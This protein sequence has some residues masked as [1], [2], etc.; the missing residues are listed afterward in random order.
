M[1]T[2][3]SETQSGRARIGAAAAAAALATALATAPA[4]AAATD[5]APDALNI[6]PAGQY[7][8]PGPGADVQ[9]KMYDGLTPLFR[10]VT[11][12]DL[13][14]YF[15][16][17]RFGAGGQGPTTVEPIPGKPG[18][19]VVRDRFNVP[20]V[21]AR[22]RADI[23][24]ATGW[25]FAEDRHLLL[26]Q[27][28]F[29]AR[30]EAVDVPNLDGFG[31]VVGL[32]QFV[33]SAAT[34]RRIAQQT[35]VLQGAGAVGRQIL[36]DIDAYTAGINQSYRDHGY[37]L[38]QPFTRVDIY[39]VMALIGDIFGRGGGD[40][41][42]RS[43][44]LDGLQRRLGARAGTQAFND[45]RERQDPEAVVTSPGRFPY[46]AAPAGHP[47]NVVLDNGSFQE[48][49]PAKVSATA[50]ASSR[51]HASN[52]LVV[53]RSR[54]A[55]GRPLFV[56]GPQIGYNFPGL[57]YELDLH[58]GG[59]DARGASAPGLPGYILIGRNQDAAWSLTSAGNDLIDTFAETLCGGS[60]RRY[61][62]QGRCRTMTRFDA[63]VL[64]GAGSA[65]DQRVRFSETVHGPVV[66]YGRVRGRLV[67]LTRDRASRG[68]DAA[69]LLPFEAMSANRVRSPKDFI[70]AFAKSPFTFNAIYADHRDIATY[71]AGLLPQRAP[72]VDIGLPTKGTGQYEWRG[73]LPAR[74]H[75]QSIDPPSGLLVNWNGKP[76]LGFSS[77]D[78]EWTYGSIQRKDLL[79]GELARTSKHTLAT[80]T[81]A[82]NAAAT[83]DLY[84][85][86][87]WPTIRA[88]L[89]PGTGPGARAEQLA[90]LLDR[91]RAAGGSRLDRD[92][93]GKVDDPGA[94][95]MDVAFPRLG[96]AALQPVLGAKLVRQLGTLISPTDPA[97]GGYFSGWQGYLDKDLRR[98]AGR[99]V[100]GPYALR[101]CGR[102]SLARCRTDLWRALDQAGA[103]LAAKQ[104]P[105]PAAW[106]ASAA[107][108]AIEFSPL[109][110]ITVRWT[111]RP[112]GIQQVISFSGHR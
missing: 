87:A 14:T 108:E 63:G 44:F 76:A 86:R 77:A 49:V 105:D 89:K 80:V 104:G 65:P 8:L 24:F 91:W 55:T 34:D 92:G 28:R 96:A 23:A 5:Y 84:V 37:P 46:G 17:A 51:R 40:E 103:A 54:S 60:K 53:G 70:G 9:A 21:T 61:L 30:V 19:T 95:I 15:K 82:M 48:E 94:A 26:D 85:V 36:A 62:Y 35:K 43:E 100:R 16:P 106:R 3:R 67:A 66:G 47:G 38:S 2:R 39:S 52:F 73:F 11:P 81:G 18:I 13:T 20:H 25:L 10:T 93:D 58:G 110:L 64:K 69:F 41:A 112:S 101:Y 42:R 79:T 4:A 88:I 109:K 12:S 32:R 31:L 107:S 99:R 59:I 68:R 83:E 90:T 78:D 22:T 33:P 27:G 71:S 56:A 45:L 98:L 72:G 50:A 74:G 111:N 57:T 1:G 102:G 97:P 7:E 75:P 29:N 6:I